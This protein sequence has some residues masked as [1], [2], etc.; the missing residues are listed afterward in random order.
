MGC[1]R[2]VSPVSLESGCTAGALLP[3]LVQFVPPTCWL[4]PERDGVISK[5]LPS[6]NSEF[7]TQHSITMPLETTVSPSFE[8]KKMPFYYSRN[9]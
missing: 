1:E 4:P 5:S 9:D 6:A 3:C 2:A 8:E 7:T